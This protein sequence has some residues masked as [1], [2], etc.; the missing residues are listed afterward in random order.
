MGE[1]HV[2]CL[3]LINLTNLTCCN[4]Y[5]SLRLIVFFLQHSIVRLSSVAYDMKHCHLQFGFKNLAP[6]LL[7]SAKMC[8]ETMD[9]R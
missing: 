2:L 1:K 3:D 8:D 4:L 7:K 9:Y 5:I 6:L